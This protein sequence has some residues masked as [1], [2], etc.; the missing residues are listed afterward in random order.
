MAGK[1]TEFHYSRQLQGQNPQNQNKLFF[2]L[3]FFFCCFSDCLVDRCEA[4]AKQSRGFTGF[5]TDQTRQEKQ[6]DFINLDNSK[7]KICRI[8]TNFSSSSP[9]AS[10][11]FLSSPLALSIAAVKLS[12]N[13]TVDLQ[14]LPIKEGRK[15]DRI[16]L[17][18]STPRPKSANPKQTFLLPL[19][20][21]LLLLRLPCDRCEAVA[22]QSRGFTDLDRS[23][24]AGITRGFH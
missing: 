18:S 10:S 22:K 9:S 4:V 3:F 12:H 24:T 11:F 7:A 21:L 23:N 19:F 2:F 8:K 6:E 14:L 15:N 17:F 5:A 13:R 1:T 16:S 20:L